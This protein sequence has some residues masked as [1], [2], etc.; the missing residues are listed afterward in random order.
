MPRAFEKAI[1]GESRKAKE[2]IQDYIIRMDQG[3]KELR[4][5]G[6]ELP[7]IVKGYVMFR[8]ANLGATQEDQVTTW[9][10]G[11][12]ER[13]EIVKAMRKLEKVQKECNGQKHYVTEEGEADVYVEGDFWGALRQGRFSTQRQGLESHIES[14]KLRT[15]CAK[16]GCIG[17]WARECTNPP[18]EHAQARQASGGQAKGSVMSGKSGFVHVGNFEGAS[19]VTQHWNQDLWQLPT[20][21]MFLKRSTCLE[22]QSVRSPFCGII[23]DAERGVVDTAAQSGLIG[24]CALGRLERSLA[25]HG[26]KVRSTNKQGQARGVEG[27][28]IAIGVVDLPIGIAGVNGIL[29]VTVIKDDIPLLLPVSLLRDLHA[30]VDL[31]ENKLVLSKFGKAT[32]MSVMQSGHVT[33]SVLEFDEAGWQVPNDAKSMGLSDEQ[34]HLLASG[35][36][37][38]ATEKLSAIAQPSTSA[39]Y[40]VYRRWRRILTQILNLIVTYDL[41]RSGQVPVP[42]GEVED[43][44]EGGLPSGSAQA[45]GP[46]V[47]QPPWVSSQGHLSKQDAYAEMIQHGI[48][49][50]PRK[51]ANPTALPATTCSHPKA[52]LAGAGNQHQREVYCKLCNSRWKIETMVGTA[53]PR[54]AQP[55]NFIL[56][57]RTVSKSYD[58]SAYDILATEPYA[59]HSNDTHVERYGHF[60]TEHDGH[61]LPLQTSSQEAE[62][63]KRSMGPAPEVSPEVDRMKL[64]VAEAQRISELKE[65]AL[66][67]KELMMKDEMQRREMALMEAQNNMG[68]QA[69]GLVE[70]AMSHA[71]MKHEELMQAQRVQHQQQIETLQTQLMWMTA[72]A[73]E[74]RVAQVMNDPLA[75]AQSMRQAAE[76]RQAMMQQG[77]QMQA[78][79]QQS[80]GQMQQTQDF[81]GPQNDW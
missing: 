53:G 70:A 9:A 38:A 62:E 45:Y 50:P 71:N 59:L 18:D 75:Q 4:D 7:S 58:A 74:E 28:A 40:H 51:S 60:N 52:Q 69:Q 43:W 63:L 25:S 47:N 34:F 6:V 46:V 48:P 2:S 68:M 24:E 20:L 32:N 57:E 14:L 55:C 11:N 12:F 30:K 33:V 67:E 79:M 13:A 72:V 81:Q 80:Q 65:A 73:G 17:H 66:K 19:F 27:Q 36:S 39:L 44:H 64:E 22:S 41:Q 1:Y 8:Q 16:C 56:A 54:A 5:E 76:L 3:F 42:E 29:E 10:S 21:G 61:G 37:V 31:F 15:R 49:L 26:L 23:T 35:P 78:M 77:E